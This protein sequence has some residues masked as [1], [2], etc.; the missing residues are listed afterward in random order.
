MDKLGGGGVGWSGKGDVCVCVCSVT[1]CQTITN[2]PKPEASSIV[3]SEIP[4]SS[5]ILSSVSAINDDDE[6]GGHGGDVTL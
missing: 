4:Y 1:Q 5:M 3:N 6:D 2:Y